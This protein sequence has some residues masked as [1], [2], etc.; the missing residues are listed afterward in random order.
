MG[1][2]LETGGFEIRQLEVEIER[3]RTKTARVPVPDGACDH[4]ELAAAGLEVAQ[5]ALEA[6]REDTWP[7]PDA[8]IVIGEALADAAASGPE[9]QMAT[10]CRPAE[11][12]VR[13]GHADW[14]HPAPDFNTVNA[15]IID[16]I[17]RSTGG[18][19]DRH[20][21]WSEPLFWETEPHHPSQAVVM[22][23]IA[24]IVAEVAADMAQRRPMR[25]DPVAAIMAEINVAI[26]KW[27]ELHG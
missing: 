26:D 17:E 7:V 19:M 25:R 8:A 27:R 13:A 22:L 18:S 4:R 10:I 14:D 15:A 21:P 3:L 9:D 2:V 6:I 12:L 5:M 20:A 1:E 23:L 11:A 16:M 24:P